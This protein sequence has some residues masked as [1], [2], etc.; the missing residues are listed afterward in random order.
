MN[1]KLND[2]I[3]WAENSGWSVKKK[4]SSFLNFNK[5]IKERYSSIPYEYQELL[6]VVEELVSPDEKTWFIC[7][8]D[9]NSE[10]GSAFKWNEFE[11]IS[12]EAAEGDIEWQQEIISW[13]DK[14]LPIVMSVK[15]GYS[16][17]A[18]DLYN[19]KGA[20]VEGR[21]PEFEE[22][23]KVANDLNAF[24]DLMMNNKY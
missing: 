3:E 1:K 21:E 6:K 13:W 23:K 4:E 2:F 22:T 16:F 15:D 12:L 5:E 7:E 8:S 19:E 20:I 10:S 18:I 9:Y 14:Y 11:M 17:F 24:F